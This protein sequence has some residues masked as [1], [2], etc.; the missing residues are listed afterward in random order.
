LGKRI[1]VGFEGDLWFVLHLMIAG[2]LHWLPAGEERA[3]KKGRSRGAAGKSSRTAG[4]GRNA[5]AVFEFDNG[6]LV[7]TEAGTQKR[8]ALHVVAGEA[9]LAAHRRPGLEIAEATPEEF[10]AA[11]KRENHTL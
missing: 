7:L 8:A 11:L 6:T 2:R 5:L 3:R 10:A 9:G 1:A 4:F